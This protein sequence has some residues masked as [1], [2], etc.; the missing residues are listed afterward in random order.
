MSSWEQLSGNLSLL[1]AWERYAGKTQLGEK[2]DLVLGE[3]WCHHQKHPLGQS[4]KS[5]WMMHSILGICALIPSRV[6]AGCIPG[7][8]WAAHPRPTL[9]LTLQGQASQTNTF[10]S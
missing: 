7:S 5:S 1:S 3:T 4:G 8:L 6:L 10:L 9:D 2:V